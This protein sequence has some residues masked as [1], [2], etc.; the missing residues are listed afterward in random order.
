MNV[1]RHPESYSLGL[2]QWSAMQGIDPRTGLIVTATLLAHLASPSLNFL[3][4]QGL[5][6]ARLP[7]LAIS[8]SDVAIRRAIHNL[9][10]LII[11]IQ[12][13]L[14]GFSHEFRM[15]EV[16]D[17]MFRPRSSG[18]V[19]NQVEEALNA[20]SPKSKLFDKDPAYLLNQ[21]L[22]K[23]GDRSIRFDTLTR[24]RII[25]A[26]SLPQDLIASAAHCHHG[27]GLLAGCIATLPA[28]AAKRAARIDMISRILEGEETTIAPHLTRSAIQRQTVSL[29][30]IIGFPARTYPLL[31]S[32]DR[33]F[34]SR[35]I[36]ISG[37]RPPQSIS[38]A[39]LDA[40]EHFTTTFHRSATHLIAL[41]RAASAANATFL[42]ESSRIEFQQRHHEYLMKFMD[43]PIAVNAPDVSQLPALAAWALLRL[44]KNR[45]A[46]SNVVSMAFA[47]AEHTWENTHRIFTSHEQ[48]AEAKRRMDTAM[49]IIRKLRQKDYP[50][51]HLQLLRSFNKQSKCIYERPLQV[52]LELG[53]VQRDE[54]NRYQLRTTETVALKLEDFIE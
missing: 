52:L 4:Q 35:L 33:D 40:A 9:C 44:S 30:G 46:E 36:P 28:E 37:S 39:D 16:V 47:A 42:D 17:A 31:F 5:G 15:D 24:P 38:T 13:R 23:G 50:V 11:R 53:H 12:D 18:L 14:V 34:L 1:I 25:I 26:G 54:Q 49:D 41:R 27:T 48:A 22:E 43:H 7:T 3:D 45:M 51:T 19:T 6:G 32:H 21:D 20:G 29:G 8:E 10:T 2:D